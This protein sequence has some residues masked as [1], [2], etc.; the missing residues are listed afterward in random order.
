MPTIAF[1]ACRRGALIALSCC[2]TACTTVESQS[3]R[4]NPDSSVESAQV[5]SDADFSRYDRLHA[6]EMGIFSPQGSVTS[7]EDVQ[8]IRD[9]FREA[10]LAELQGYVIVTEPEP[11]AM[12]VQ[13]S[14]ID[15][16]QAA[17][18]DTMSVR[19]DLREIATPGKIVF[20]MEMRDSVSNRI[21]GRAA[22]SAQTPA[23]ADEAGETTDWTSVEQAAANWALLF[24]QFL[25]DNLGR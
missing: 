23:I 19:S 12:T 18:Q 4:V 5:A 10:F 7:A 8:R 6:V 22:D 3:F 17:Y 15:F 21:L 24:R 25:D 1:P 9:L 20:L 11:G 16:R 2:L 13:A 14:L